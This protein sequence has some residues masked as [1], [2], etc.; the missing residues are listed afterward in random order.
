ME[1]NHNLELNFFTPDYTLL[2]PPDNPD[3]QPGRE[4]ALTSTTSAI[5]LIMYHLLQLMVVAELTVLETARCCEECQ[6]A[7]VPT[8]LQTWA[9]GPDGR[10][11]VVHAAQ[12]R[13]IHER[14]ANTPC[15]SPGQRQIC[16][17]LRAASLFYGAVALCSYADRMPCAH[18]CAEEQ[19]GVELVQPEIGGRCC[20]ALERW[21][22]EGDASQ[23]A[24]LL[25]TP[26][27]RC[28]V[29]GMVA[30]YQEQLG[31]NWPFT[32]RFMKFQRT[33]LK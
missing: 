1:M 28:S 7:G 8:R 22:R 21:V 12:L 2:P 9:T 26:V 20:E 13:R 27:C 24:L 29:P 17:P 4:D 25:G 18:D 31:A 30:W 15:L 11:A 14:E 6:D 10:R 23:G 19:G 33:L 16:N 32:F 5:N 3:T